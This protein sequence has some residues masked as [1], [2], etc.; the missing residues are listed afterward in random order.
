MSTLLLIIGLLQCVHGLVEYV[1]Y[2]TNKKDVPTCSQINDALINI[3]GQ[4]K[5]QIYK[6]QSRQTTEFWLVQALDFQ[7]SEVLRI[8]GVRN[9]T[10]IKIFGVIH[11]DI[12]SR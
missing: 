12:A 1:V 5:V 10:P 8:A 9:S 11:S 7:T 6:S 3:L 4:S 2:P